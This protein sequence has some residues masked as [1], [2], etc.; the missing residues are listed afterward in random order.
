MKKNILILL[1]LFNITNSHGFEYLTNLKN[2]IQNYDYNSLLEKAKIG[3]DKL[4]EFC[5]FHKPELQKAGMVSA[6][7]LS[8]YLGYKIYKKI[9]GNQKVATVPKKV[10]V[11]EIMSPAQP[12]IVVVP[13]NPESK[14]ES[15]RSRELT[16]EERLK[17]Q[18]SNRSLISRQSNKAKQWGFRYYNFVGAFKNLKNVENAFNLKS[19][20][21]FRNKFEE[22][23]SNNNLNY[24]NVYPLKIVYEEYDHVSQLKKVTICYQKVNGNFVTYQKP[25]YVFE[26]IKLNDH[27]IEI[28]KELGKDDIERIQDLLTRNPQLLY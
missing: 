12:I 11:P 23:L 17:L 3:K 9:N 21:E 2:Y 25:W 10:D 16:E 4:N 27:E 13:S 7:L 28:N 24:Q 8:C 15:K 20:H 1:F 6:A 18:G 14:L 19:E 22:F 5:K 26:I